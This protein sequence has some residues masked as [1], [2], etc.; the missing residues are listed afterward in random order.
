[1]TSFEVA[2][3][4]MLPQSEVQLSAEDQETFEKLIDVL[5][6]LED[7]QHVYHNVELA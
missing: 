6:E 4:E 7:V 2:E 5:E 1:M 3:L